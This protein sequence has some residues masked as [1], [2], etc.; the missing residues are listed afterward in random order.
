MSFRTFLFVL[1]S[2]LPAT[3]ALAVVPIKATRVASGLSRPVYVTAAPG[4]SSRLYIVEQHTGQI[5]ILNL[6]GPN[7]GAINPTPFLDIDGLATGNEQGLLGLAFHPNYASNGQ[8]YVNYTSTGGSFGLGVTNVRRYVRSGD[9][10]IAD[11]GSGTAVMS[12]DQPQ[13]NHNGGWIGF[14]PN[15]GYLYVASGDGGNGDDAGPGHTEPGGNAQDITDN[16]F[17]KILRLDVNG[18]DFGADPNRNYA[19]PTG[20]TG[21]PLAN[22]FAGPTAGDD[23]IWSYGLRNPFRASFDRATGDLYIGDVGQDNRE[24]VDFQPANSTGGENYG[25][26]LREGEIPT[27]TG[28][29]G[30]PPPPGNVEPIHTYDR[31]TGSVIT[32]G[33]VLRSGENPTLDGTY[34]FTD[35]G[36]QRI[37]SFKYDGTSKTNF[38]EYTGQ[39]PADVGSIGRIASFGEDDLGR[40]YMVELFGGE[41]F[42]LTPAGPG[43]AD[44][45]D[46]VDLNDLSSLAA[47][48]GALSN[49]QW[50]QGD[51][52]N[53]GDVDLADLST[54][55]TY[56]GLGEAQAF[57]DFSSLISVPEPA[58]A[59]LLLG[60]FEVLNRRRRR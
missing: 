9:P 8:F 18:D 42:R 30:G 32:G 22:P 51:F 44:F 53:D 50:S 28:G 7:S 34:F 3:S 19:I 36:S 35:H 37:F 10:N 60:L 46:D 6:T 4:D 45:D 23:E 41:V 56:Y 31:D 38:H 54:L 49:A 25:W 57:A 55:A 11:A 13:A 15:D 43:D 17:G 29:V 14:G 52:D 2:A 24:E 48:Y 1:T 58:T 16:P 59:G 33:Y 39:I 21:Q 47:S 20:G 26:R 5:K 27:P 12:F 40:L